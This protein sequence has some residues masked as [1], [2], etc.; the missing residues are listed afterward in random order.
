MSESVDIKGIFTKDFRW[1][2]SG[3]L[4]YEFLKTAHQLFLFKIIATIEYG[5]MGYI[6]SIVYLTISI[7][8][9]GFTHSLP[10]YLSTFTRSQ[11]H[12]R[13]LFLP[14]GFAQAILFT[15]AAGL[16]TY[17]AITTFSNLNIHFYLLLIPSLIILEGVRASLRF[18]L[19]TMFVTRSTQIIENSIT[20][21]L[22]A[23]IWFPYVV[24]G[25]V[26]TI[27][28]IFTPYL[29]ASAIATAALIINLIRTYQQLPL[30]VE[31]ANEE[32]GLFWKIT[33]T[34]LFNFS[35][36]QLS[37]QLFSTNFL[38]ALFSTSIGLEKT[39]TLKCASYLADALKSIVKSTVGF[40]GN[41]LLAYH[42][43]ATLA[44][45]RMAFYW[46]GE[47]FYR[48][49]TPVISFLT[50]TYFL[51]AYSRNQLDSAQSTIIYAT[52]FIGIG[53]MDHL[54][55]MYEQFYMVEEQANKLFYIRFLEW[56]LLYILF[57]HV[58]SHNIITILSML[59]LIRAVSLATLVLH[60][61]HHWSIHP[62]IRVEYRYL[63][64]TVIASWTAALVCL[65]LL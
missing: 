22:L 61:Y 3:S 33:K 29:V 51:F 14:Y 44:A 43:H 59:I 36:I 58:S 5:L 45:K 35:A 64:V 1:N 52:L 46:I 9:L 41:A 24:Y 15:L 48:L 32:R 60:A 56:I 4:L 11:Y 27:T 62:L 13:K 38:V 2:V 40:S 53:L 6:F 55:Y 16:A 18:F 50:A 12:F 42:K 57:Q 21:G 47:K 63:I 28:S 8:D 17:K 7:A 25:T 31:I 10:P 34:R 23:T 39:A 19:H 30:Y 26:P 65:K 20:L 49:Y 54:F 37:K